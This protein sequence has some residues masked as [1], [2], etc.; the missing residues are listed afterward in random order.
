MV[1]LTL[2]FKNIRLTLR[3]P[4]M[5]IFLIGMPI[6]M[7]FLMNAVLSP[8]AAAS[9]LVA[10]NIG[11]MVDVISL[12]TKPVGPMLNKML[13]TVLIQML[14]VDGIVVTYNLSS[15]REQYTWMRTYTMPV[16]KFQMVVG[17]FLGYMTIMSCLAFATVIITR[18]TMGIHWSK[19][20]L[21]LF[22]ITILTAVVAVALGLVL[23]AITKNPKLSSVVGTLIV[24]VMTMLSG[25]FT[26]N[27]TF[28]KT[29]IFT[30]NKWAADSFN[31]LLNG[32]TL[33]DISTNLFVLVLI[34]LGLLTASWFI[35]RR[36]AIYE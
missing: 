29:A 3:S 13:S 36:E 10:S 35:L 26:D 15:E 25:G 24:M 8:D 1:I 23:A 14:L 32:G 9:T 17:N 28:D 33:A 5:G 2:A 30:V 19:D 34:T 18:Y 22:C 6:F 4:I 7:I 12:S 16:S 21:G 11:G 27:T 31:V 20:I